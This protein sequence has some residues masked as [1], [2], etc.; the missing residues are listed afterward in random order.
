[1]KQHIFTG[2]GAPVTAPTG[3]GHHYVDTSTGGQYLSKGTSSA[4]DW[5]AVS[6]VAFPVTS[7]FG[8]TGAVVSVSGDYSASQITNTPAGDIVATNLQAAINELDTEKLTVAHKGTG[9]TAE[10]PLVTGAVAGFMSPSDFTKLSGVANGATANDTDANL[11]N[12]ANHTGTQVAATISDFSTEVD[13]RITLQKGV[14]L[15]L[16]TLDSGG[17]VP[18]SQLPTAIAGSVSY[19]G[20][21]NAT[22]NSPALA[23]SVGT[24]GYY[25][26]VNVAG[27]TNLDGITD[28]KVG[29]WAI[30]NGGQ[31]EKVDN[32]ESV[33]S[34]AGKTGAVTLDKNDVGLS[35]VDNTSDANKPVS[36]A[37]ATAIGLKLSI[38]SN[39][40]DLASA[41]TAR[42]NLGLG[43]AALNDTGDFAPIAHV[44]AGGSEHAAATTSVAGFMS[45]ADKTK[46]DGVASGATAGITALTGEV[47]ASGP[48]SAAATLSNAAVIAKVLTGFTSQFG[49][50]TAADS[51]LSALQKVT[52]SSG[53]QPKV[54]DQSVVMPSNWSWIRTETELASGVTVEIGVESTI[55]FI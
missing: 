8:R 24:K 36:T 43:S 50:A 34:V 15:G 3:I 49:V 5:V 51:I 47:T 55:N 17:K 38:A 13:A 20:T 46:L 32:T 22:S 44:G 52:Y 18:S 54:I 30:Y 7:V 35:N 37:Q 27:S 2:V 42:T 25:Y 40:S 33:L 16:A 29:D 19:Q 39:L 53:L 10:H 21:W 9:G 1:M 23:S 4:A 48:G 12:R 31:W 28:W 14:A 45:A 41:S 6:A 11:K 26:V